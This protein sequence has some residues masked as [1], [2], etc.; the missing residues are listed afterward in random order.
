MRCWLLS[1]ALV[2]TA[3]G[4]AD[5]GDDTKTTGDATTTGDGSTGDDSGF[6]VDGTTPGCVNLECRQ[7]ICDGGGKTTI[8]GTVHDPAGKVPLY[9]VVVYVPNAAVE[10]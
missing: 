1:C 5:G 6:N 10:P 2:L 8:S 4:S 3:C 9:N 7:V